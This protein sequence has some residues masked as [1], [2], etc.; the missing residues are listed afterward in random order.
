MNTGRRLISTV[1]IVAT[2]L[3]LAPL[4]ALFPGAGRPDPRGPAVP[5]LVRAQ[6]RP[7]YL[8]QAARAPPMAPTAAPPAPGPRGRGTP[9]P[10]LHP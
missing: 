2:A 10:R 7:L 6:T 9:A 4:L 8:P 1:R 3:L 5:A